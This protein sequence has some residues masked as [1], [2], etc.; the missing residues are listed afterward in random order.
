M[1]IVKIIIV[2]TVKMDHVKLLV[3]WEQGEKA[4]IEDKKTIF[5][6]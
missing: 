6:N 3:A 1:K 4:N 2:K 5:N